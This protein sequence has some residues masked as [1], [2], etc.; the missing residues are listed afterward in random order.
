MGRPDRRRVPVRPRRRDGSEYAFFGS[1]HEVRP[2][3]LIVQT[4]AYEGF[5][6]GV[7]LDR[8]EFEDLP[9]GRCRLT[10]TSL[11]D[12]FEGRDAFVASGM[13]VASARATRS[14]TSSSP[15]PPERE[16]EATAS[17]MERSPAVMLPGLARPG[18]TKDGDPLLVSRA[19]SDPACGLEREPKGPF[20]PRSSRHCDF[21]VMTRF[22][23]SKS[24][25]ICRQ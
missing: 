19:V 12:S 25:D 15:R 18:H 6:D 4:F 11:V 14:S 13:E 17:A 10:S 20:E 3:R 7:S 2:D 23:W 21:T 22:L 8:L 16:D 1:V 5:P 24:N 9:D